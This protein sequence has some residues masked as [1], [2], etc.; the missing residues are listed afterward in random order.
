VETFEARLNVTYAGSNGDLV[1]P[2]NFD[3]TDEDIRSWAT[4]AVRAGNIPGIAADPNV[5]FSNFVIDRFTAN[6]TRPYQLCQIR[7]KTPFGMKAGQSSR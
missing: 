4:E 1:D 5:D 3:A 2:I 7:P 6:D